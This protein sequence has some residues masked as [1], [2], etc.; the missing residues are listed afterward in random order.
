MT[1]NEFYTLKS[2][3]QMV[4]ILDNGQFLMKRFDTVGVRVRLYYCGTFFA[5]LFYNTKTNAIL[6]HRAF[7]SDKL[8]EP[9]LSLIKLS[10][11]K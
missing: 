11:I 4:Y 3:N 5:E 6:S 1:L 7:K 2:E 10:D 8:L 9:Y